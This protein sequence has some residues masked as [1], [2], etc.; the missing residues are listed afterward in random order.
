ML[1]KTIQTT[2]QVPVNVLSL[3]WNKSPTVKLQELPCSACKKPIG[4][5]R[6]G[7]AWCQDKTK[8]AMRLCNE[9][10]EKAEQAL[11]EAEKE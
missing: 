8:Y 7:L 4:N 11:K 9:C 3:K 5:K 2:K 1:M 6:W 10:G